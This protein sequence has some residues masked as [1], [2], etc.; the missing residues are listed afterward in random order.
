MRIV[1]SAATFQAMELLALTG[2]KL[3]T[4]VVDNS[5]YFCPYNCCWSSWVFTPRNSLLLEQQGKKQMALE[6]T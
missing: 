3:G 4:Y 5:V 2:G 1:V 6:A